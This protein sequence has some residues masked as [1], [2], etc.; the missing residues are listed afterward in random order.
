MLRAAADG[1]RSVVLCPSL[2]YGEGRG[3]NPDSIA[4]SLGLGSFAWA[5]A[6]AFYFLEVLVAFVQAYVFTMLSAVFIGSCIQ[7][8]H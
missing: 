5:V 4:M 3:A 1:V 2:I 7:P 8:E 6:V